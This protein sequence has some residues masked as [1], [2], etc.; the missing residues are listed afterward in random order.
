MRGFIYLDVVREKK[1]SK[2][3]REK[4][5][6]WTEGK[7]DLAEPQVFLV[8]FCKIM[9]EICSSL[10]VSLSFLFASSDGGSSSFR[11]CQRGMTA[12]QVAG[13]GTALITITARCNSHVNHSS[14]RC[15]MEEWG[16]ADE[17]G[18]HAEYFQEALIG[19]FVSHLCKP[20]LSRLWLVQQ[21]T[22]NWT[23][24]CQNKS[25]LWGKVELQAFSPS[26]PEETTAGAAWTLQRIRM[27]GNSALFFPDC[28][29]Q[30][31]FQLK[32]KNKKKKIFLFGKKLPYFDV[33]TFQYM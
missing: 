4:K 15:R 16:A 14:A 9:W 27:R 2:N 11:R 3:V 28:K 10:T 6:E 31:L 17:G 26:A 13:P 22:T 24:C 32:K 25:D 33:L 18:V 7:K 19:L 29:N 20:V 23:S 1:K 21:E 30:T 8:F 5:V 12:G